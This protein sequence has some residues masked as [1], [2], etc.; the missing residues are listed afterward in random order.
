MECFWMVLAENS[1]HTQVRHANRGLANKEAARLAALNPG[2]MF[3][4]LRSEGHALKVDPV[5]WVKHDEIP[6]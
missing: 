4:V 3:H 2:V 1:S 5:S 6:F